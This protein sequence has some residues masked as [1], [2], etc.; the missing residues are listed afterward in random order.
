MS[1]QNNGLI[2][3]NQN[4]LVSSS[5][6]N[7]FLYTF[8]AGAV[9]FKK[10][11]QIA[12]QSL[13]LYYSWYNISAALG[14]NSFSFVWYSGSGPTATTVNVVIPDGFYTVAQLNAYLQYVMVQNL[15]YLIDSSGNFVYFI[16]LTTNSV[17]YRIEII[18]DYLLTSAQA[19]A[20]SY[21]QPVGAPSYVTTNITPQVVIPDTNIQSYLGF[22]AG[23][24]PPATQSTTYSVN[25]QNVPEVSPQS[26]IY[27]LCS[28]VRN[29][30]A[31]PQSIVI[32]FVPNVTYGS[33]ISVNP[34]FPQYL[35]ILEGNY[36]YFTCNFTDQN[37]NPLPI[38]DTNL[39]IVFSLRDR[40][41]FA[42][43]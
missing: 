25:G 15:M 18:C 13:N 9:N 27:L 6:N 35:N 32:N 21:T 33:Q 11:D 31:V 19:S 3:I 39:S 24:Y 29:L 36:A 20:L 17:S 8:P 12:L 37:Y 41:G 14:N 2:A 38:I 7:Q 22:N 23:T 4:N 40:D 1:Y 26:S 43:S 5:I 30:Y 34:T 42:T 16:T 10:G 28:L